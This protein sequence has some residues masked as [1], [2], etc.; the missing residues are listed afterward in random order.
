MVTTVPVDKVIIEEVNGSL[1]GDPFTRIE[2]LEGEEYRF[3]RWVRKTSVGLP[4]IGRGI[5]VSRFAKL[6]ALRARA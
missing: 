6:R 3:W 1:A 4:S 5:V 2:R